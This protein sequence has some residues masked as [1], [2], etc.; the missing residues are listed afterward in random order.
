MISPAASP[1]NAAF[2]DQCASPDRT[3]T[4]TTSTIAVA[5]GE[6]VLLT[7]GSFTGGIDALPAGGTLC[8]AAGA[9][10]APPYMNNAAGS[11][12]VA[13]GATLTMPFVS[14][15][16]GF[17]LSVEGTA[18]VAGL[19]INGS[20]S[21]DVAAGGDLTI[22]NNFSP[23]TGTITN[24]G[25]MHIASSMNLNSSVS[26]TN[27][28]TLTIDQSSTVNGSFVNTGVAQVTGSL[29]VNGSGLLQNDCAIAMTGDLSNN[30]PSSTNQGLVLVTGRFSNNGTWRQSAVGT[31]DSATLTDDGHVT[32]FGQYHFSGSTSVQG[33]F[34]GDTA[35]SPIV[36]DST[37]PPGQIF[38]VQTGTVTNVV[39]G[40]V[41][42]FNLRSYPAPDCAT[43]RPAADIIVG[44]TGPAT[45]TQ[46]STLTYTISVANAGPGAADAVVVTDALPAGLTGV[47]ASAGGTVSATSVTW[48]LGTVAAATTVTLTVTGTVTSAPG[49]IL[50]DTASAT[51]TTPDPDPTNNNGT[52]DSSRATTL[53]VPVIVPNTR[54]VADDL[55]VQGVTGST[56]LGRVTA[57]D[58]Q[59]GQTLHFSVVSGPSN[60][61]LVM[62]P[63]GE[64]DYRSNASFTGVDTATFQACDNGVPSLCDQGAITFNI[65][66]IASDDIAQTFE[67]VSV[68]IPLVPDNASPGAALVSPL[69]TPPANGTATLAIAAGTATY[70]PNTGFLGTDTFEFRVCSPTAPTLCDTATITVTVIRLNRPPVIDDLTMHTT[71]RVTVQGQL[72]ISDPDGDAVTAIRGIPARSGTATVDPTGLTLYNPLGGFAGRDHYTA[73]ACDA[74][75]PELCSTGMVTVEVVPVALADSATTTAGVAVTV[76]V[77]ANDIGT[78]VA[79]TVVSGPTN[80]TVA[81]AG[82]AFRYTPDAG[83]V[84]TDTFTYSICAANAADLCAVATATI[85]VTAAVV[86]TPTPTPLPPVTEGS[87]GSLPDTG[88]DLGG[89]GWLGFLAV[90][91]GA[92]MLIAQA[93]VRRVRRRRPMP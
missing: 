2:A 22:S 52:S 13:G 17:A 50:T 68:V 27:S 20:S 91:A 19:N 86:P 11:L 21:I 3:L 44:K 24:A 5:A 55:V 79:P 76:T 31:L 1:A 87:A 71:A 78:V 88:S 38:D 51:S 61:R 63:G 90:A 77:L 73:I 70:K 65:F 7:G 39:R 47:T 34:V 9:T 48:N 25:T 41:G 58:A 30:G 23:A 32:G 56:I 15:G 93:T 53:V 16:T 14:V 18:V 72:S 12:L 42:R 92:S 89:W 36:V 85:T 81:A 57:T 69:V 64:F 75:S 74:G 62:L 37:A 49:T 54:P 45:V 80:G 28:G 84:G 8:V 35:S 33:S 29:T 43:P 67:N 46:N 60:G 26:L 6:T 10:L 66:P 40:T 4:P 83:F 59:A 82:R